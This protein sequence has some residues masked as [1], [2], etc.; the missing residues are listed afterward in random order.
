MQPGQRG[1]WL[2]PNCRD[3]EA[4]PPIPSG[5]G[6]LITSAERPMGSRV[7]VALGRERLTSECV[8]LTDWDKEGRRSQSSTVEAPEFFDGEG[9]VGLERQISICHKKGQRVTHAALGPEGEWVVIGEKYDGSVKNW[10]WGGP[11]SDDLANYMREVDDLR[12]V[13]FGADGA[14]VAVNGDN[15]FYCSEGIAKPLEERLSRIN[16]NGKRV[17]NVSLS[18]CHSS[19]YWILDD[20][21]SQWANLG[22]S[23]AGE[24]N[25]SSESALQVFACWDLFVLGHKGVWVDAAGSGADI[26]A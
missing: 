21:G 15:G 9:A 19:G 12:L 3:R 6:D 17:L 24:L 25:N 7:I 8:I 14:W 11:I 23:L 22:E 18:L 26:R 5:S 16:S 2:F 1:M 10:W 13:A 4:A 20:D